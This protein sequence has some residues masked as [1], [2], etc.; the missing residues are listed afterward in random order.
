MH[1]LVVC[2]LIALIKEMIIELKFF[3]QILLPVGKAS[4]FLNVRIIVTMNIWYN[5]WLFGIKGICNGKDVITS[6]CFVTIIVY[7]LPCLCFSS[8]PWSRIRY[9]KGRSTRPSTIPSHPR[10][11]QHTPPAQQNMPS[12]WEY[13]SED[14]DCFPLFHKCHCYHLDKNFLSEVYIMWLWKWLPGR[15]IAITYIFVN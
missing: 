8:P 12:C 11:R 4:R 10:W 6:L 3:L 15:N 13:E 5:A 14:M 7:Y 1:L 2:I 9:W